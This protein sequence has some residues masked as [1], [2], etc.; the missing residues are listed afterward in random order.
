[1]MMMMTKEDDSFLLIAVS[2][3]RTMEV[4]RQGL[5]ANVLCNL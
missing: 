3:S 2:T 1:M 5:D 4:L